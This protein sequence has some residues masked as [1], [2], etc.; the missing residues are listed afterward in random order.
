LGLPVI[1][2]TIPESHR[3]LAESSVNNELNKVVVVGINYSITL[4]SSILQEIDLF[5][6]E[7]KHIQ[8]SISTPE[9]TYLIFRAVLLK[10]ETGAK[11]HFQISIDASQ[12]PEARF[13]V[14]NYSERKLTFGAP[15]GSLIDSYNVDIA[16]ENEIRPPKHYEFVDSATGIEMSNITVTVTHSS[17][18]ISTLT[19][20]DQN[21]VPVKTEEGDSDFLVEVP[22]FEVDKWKVLDYK[23]YTNNSSTI[24]KCLSVKLQDS[25]FRAVLTWNSRIKDLDFY[26]TNK[27]GI[28]VCFRVKQQNEVTLDVDS[29]KGFG[30]E[31]IT[32]E[33]KAGVSYYFYANHYTKS[34]V[35]PNHGLPDS[36][37]KIQVFGLAKGTV[38]FSVH[39]DQIH[40]YCECPN[41]FWLGF[42][43]KDGE[44][45]IVNKVVLL[46]D[47]TSKKPLFF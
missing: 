15:N 22:G 25:K 44:V 14:Q 32:L 46:P 37:A 30:P 47:H 19:S 6:E 16:P 23:D 17:G 29:R 3:I 5:S 42:I 41:R 2:P 8:I 45:E 43:L 18:R 36:E 12:N 13:D 39:P 40:G 7:T 24:R 9:S 33:P 34:E 31:T 4:D 21:L 10:T 35:K 27:E 38:S 20:N 26:C 28:Y 11:I 1:D